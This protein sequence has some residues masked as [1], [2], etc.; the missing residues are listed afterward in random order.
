MKYGCSLCNS[1]LC[2]ITIYFEISYINMVGNKK[3]LLNIPSEE[4][5]NLTAISYFSY[6]LA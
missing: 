2:H 4:I 3:I 1:F 6:N 5:K